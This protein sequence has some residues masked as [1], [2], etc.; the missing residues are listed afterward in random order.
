MA[1]GNARPAGGTAVIGFLDV[2]SADAMSSRLR[3]F[4]L[5]LKDTGYVEGENV[6]FTYHFAENQTDRL[7]ELAADLVRR[8]VAVIAATAGNAAF[9][10]KAAT[11][12][13]PVVFL[14]GEDPVKLGLVASLARPSGNLTGINL[15]TAELVAKRLGLLRELVPRAARVAVMVHSADVTTTESTLAEAQAAARAEAR[16]PLGLKLPILHWPP[17]PTGPTGGVPPST[18]GLYFA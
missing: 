17:C 18:G 11:T 1:A 12:V 15:F 14:V 7:P 13:I 3:A 5:G 2:R 8:Q 9:A 10:A 4:R 6:A 16:R